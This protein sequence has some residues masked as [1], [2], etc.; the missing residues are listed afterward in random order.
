MLVKDWAGRNEVKSPKLGGFN[1]YA[2]V[3]LVVHFLQC[4]VRPPILPNLQKLF[5]ERYARN[6][7]GTVR[8]PLSLDFDDDMFYREHKEIEKNSLNVAQ[9]FMLFLDYYSR[10]DFKSRYICLRDAAI[11]WRDGRGGSG[12]ISDLFTVFIRDPMDDH[13][14][15]RT[16]RDVAYLQKKMRAA[17]DLF[18][19][20]QRFPKLSDILTAV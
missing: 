9:L 11:K 17:L 15:G 4:G 20:S 1:S 7:N 8:F 6:I 13:N 2:I 18:T 19:V 14:P 5:P 3:L 12:S 16:V 10:F